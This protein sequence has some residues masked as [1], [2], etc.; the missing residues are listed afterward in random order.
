MN[1]YHSLYT[2]MS[3]CKEELQRLHH[4]G[5]GHSALEHNILQSLK[6]VVLVVEPTKAK[7]KTSDSNFT[8]TFGSVEM[9]QVKKTTHMGMMRTCV[10][11]DSLGVET[12]VQKARRSLY[13]LL[14][15]G[16]HGE[17]GLDPESAIH[18]SQ[19]Y[20]LPVLKY[21][22]DV[23]VPTKHNL[24]LVERF[25]RTHYTNRLVKKSVI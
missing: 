9:P 17:N 7:R 1:I 2:M 13:S 16:L 20:V 12:N 11:S 24:E 21:G 15:A 23:S 4:M 6:S 5:Y 3:Y 18:V 25:L 19:L 8:W 22:L 14:P 10:L